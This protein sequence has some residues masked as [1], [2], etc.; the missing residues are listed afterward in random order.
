M[1]SVPF[2]DFLH[3]ISFP[4]SLSLRVIQ[5]LKQALLPTMSLLTIK[6]P[7]I[8]ILFNLLCLSDSSACLPLPPY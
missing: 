5:V 4:S 2:S 8:P 6:H 7:P 1:F 3:F